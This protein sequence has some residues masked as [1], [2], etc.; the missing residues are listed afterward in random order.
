MAKMTLRREP[1]LD[2]KLGSFPYQ[3]HAVE[4]IRDLPYGAI[5]HE[6]GLGKTKIAIDVM[7]Y[8]LEKKIVDTVLVVVKKSLL[9]NWLTELS[10]HCYVKPA[11]LTQNKKSNYYVFNGPA[12]IVL[13]NYEIIN[14]ELPRMKLFVRARDTGIIL[15][16]STKIKNPNSAI[17]QALFEL[18]PHFSRRLIMTGT[19]VAN[20][21][22][23]IWAQVWFLDQ[24]KS[25]GNN[26]LDFKRNIDL[27]ND[28]YM[29]KARQTEFEGQV[30]EIFQ[31]IADFSVRETKKG[32][33]LKLP[34]KV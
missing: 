22:Y 30:S 15:D 5:F 24:G 7:L 25:L 32:G 2:V 28:M 26:F 3:A 11:I 8:W 27:T 23:D 17:T 31:K 6:Q 19:P 10:E 34:K 20:R 12:R 18:S 13:A 9:L 14:S 33:V 21:P 16:E 29:D 4:A 1:R